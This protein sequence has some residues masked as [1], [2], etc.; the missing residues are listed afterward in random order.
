MFKELYFSTELDENLC[1]SYLLC[2]LNMLNY[3]IRSGTIGDFSYIK[4]LDDP[5]YW[6][7]FLFGWIFFFTV[8][9]IM[10]NVVNGIIVDTFQQL[11]EDHNKKVNDNLNICYICN[12]HRCKFE[13]EGQKFESHTDNEHSLTSYLHYLLKINLVDPQ[14]LNSLDFYVLNAVKEKRFDFFPIEKSLK[15]DKS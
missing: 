12:L 5:F 14:D 11:R 9:L 13:I 10:I 15:L 6:S 4:A 7:Y 3:G 2:F 8:M 1:S